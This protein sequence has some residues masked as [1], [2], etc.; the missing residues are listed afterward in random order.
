[1]PV[2]NGV[3]KHFELIGK[4]AALYTDWFELRQP[5]HEVYRSVA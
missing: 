1:M 4:L 2:E 5:L 3:E